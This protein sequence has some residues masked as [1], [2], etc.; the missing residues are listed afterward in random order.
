MIKTFLSDS[1]LHIVPSEGYLLTFRGDSSGETFAEMYVPISKD[2]SKLVEVKAE[3]VPVYIP[4]VIENIEEKSVDE[5][6]QYLISQTKNLLRK[7]LENNPLLFE[8][9]LY[10]VTTEAQAHL[11]AIIRAAEYANTL[12]IDYV[13]M[14]NDIEEIRQAYNL[15]TLQLLFIKIQQYV[16]KL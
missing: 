3:N 5:I 12:N 2:I 9:K 11:N 1:I 15:E 8:G 14:W 16:S 10:S 13:P 6:Q 7:F 4:E